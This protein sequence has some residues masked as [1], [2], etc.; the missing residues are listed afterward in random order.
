MAT[1]PD[2]E[3]AVTGAQTPAA[4]P[5]RPHTVKALDSSERLDELLPVTSLRLWLLALAAAVLMIATVTYA[6]V[7]PRDVTVTGEGRIVGNGGVVLVTSTAEGQFGHFVVKDG[8]RVK[9]GQLVGYV[10]TADG[11]VGQRAQVSGTLLGYLRRPGDPVEVGGWIAEVAN[12]V[13]DGTTALMIVPPDEAGKLQEGQSVVVS[14]TGGSQVRGVVGPDRSDAMAADA[15][16][17]GL[18]MIE[19]P[20]GARVV[21]QLKLDDP[22]PPGYEFTAVVLVSERTLLQQLLGIS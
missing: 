16:Q 11:P 1:Q 6:A 19:P 4:A 10:L 13:D 22:A 18:G 21:V 5:Y 7:T 15:V 2:S 14:V 9:V 12:K 8:Q 20:D 3:R 17:E